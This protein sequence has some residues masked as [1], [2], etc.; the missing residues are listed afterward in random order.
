[1]RH[2]R[3][4]LREERGPAAK[5][6]LTGRTRVSERD[7]VTAGPTGPTVRPAGVLGAPHDRSPSVPAQWGRPLVREQGQVRKP[8]PAQRSVIAF[9]RGARTGVRITLAPNEVNTPS[10][11][12]VNFASRSRTRNHTRSARSP[13][14]MT[15]LRAC[16]ATHAPVGFGSPEPT[17]PPH[18]ECPR[19]WRDGRCSCAGRSTGGRSNGGA[20]ATTSP[21]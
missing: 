21:G 1:M 9:A 13:R 6:Q 10:K 15:R 5:R 18:H 19:E 17:A 16:W 11:D 4:C 2:A 20:S 14:S 3:G 7:T 12:R 8:A